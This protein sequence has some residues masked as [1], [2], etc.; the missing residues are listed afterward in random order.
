MSIFRNGNRWI[1]LEESNKCVVVTLS[2]LIN[3]K[4]V[5]LKKIRIIESIYFIFK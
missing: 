5:S 4:I 2:I 1:K 3:F